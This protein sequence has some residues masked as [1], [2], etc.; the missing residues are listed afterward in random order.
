MLSNK[1]GNVSA[2]GRIGDL[3]QKTAFA[4]SSTL[5]V[6]SLAV[7]A[8]DS[9]LPEDGMKGNNDQINNAESTKTEG[10][11]ICAFLAQTTLVLE[12]DGPGQLSVL[13]PLYRF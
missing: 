11:R 9:S 4:S 13:I 1:A 6:A 5:G 12:R 2:L 8:L 3:M 7:Q 10:N